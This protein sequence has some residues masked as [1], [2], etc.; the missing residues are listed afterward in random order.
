M[1]VVLLHVVNLNIRAPD[2]RVY[3][4]L[5]REATWHLRRLSDFLDP[6]ISRRLRV[7]MGRVPEEIVAAARAEEPE[8]VVLAKREISPS[9]KLRRFRRSRSRA[10][11]LTS[12]VALRLVRE[13]RCHVVVLSGQSYFDCESTSILEA[14]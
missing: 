2:N 11:Q 3:E 8:I 1:Q 4:E 5:G 10:D 7:R 14:D 6:S 9:T 12:S 13:A